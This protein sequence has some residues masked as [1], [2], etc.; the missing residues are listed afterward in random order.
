MSTK[1]TDP[2]HLDID[3]LVDRVIDSYQSDERTEHIDSTFLPSRDAVIELIELLRRLFFPGFFDPERLKAD[4]LREHVTGLIAQVSEAMSTQIDHALRYAANLERDGHGDAC[5]QCTERARRI[6]GEFLRTVPAL[7]R[8]LALDVQAAFDGDPA[9]PNTDETVFCYPGLH[10]VFIH[11]VAHELYKAKVPLLPRIMNE[12]A[13][14]LTGIDIHPGAT[15]GESFFIDHG[16][17]VVIGETSVIGD[18]VKIYQSVT[19]GAPA[20]NLSQAARGVKRHPTVGGRCGRL[21]QCHDPRRQYGDR[22]RQCDRRRRVPD[23]VGTPG[24]LRLQQAAG[25][26]VS[27][28]RPIARNRS[29]CPQRNG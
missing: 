17:G 15:I 20:A 4:R 22:Q 29:R 14:S 19:I 26:E 7:R 10:A 1:P 23:F 27:F 13:H 16:T 8:T 9:A 5:D 21:R 12:H 24:P 28:G 11:R 6:A 18:R 25:T 2:S 3:A